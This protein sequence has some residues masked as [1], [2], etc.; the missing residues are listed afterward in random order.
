MVGKQK[1]WGK[2]FTAK[3]V[4]IKSFRGQIILGV[5][6]FGH[7]ISMDVTFGGHRFMVKSLIKKGGVKKVQN[8][9]GESPIEHL[10]FEYKL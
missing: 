3:D 8:V 9:W 5:E 4:H 10:I 2:N 1:F 7:F 6:T